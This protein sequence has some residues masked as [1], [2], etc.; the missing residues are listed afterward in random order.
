MADK[1]SKGLAD[2]VAASTALSDID[3]QRGPAVLPRVRHPPA[4]RI[5]RPSRKSPTCCSAAPPRAARELD[6][7]RAELAAGRPLGELVGSTTWPSVAG[8]QGPM[9]AMRTPG[10]AGQRRRSGQGLQR[11]RGQH[12]Q[13]GPAHRPAAGAGGRLPRRAAGPG[14]AARPIRASAWPRTSCCQLRG[15][16]R[17]PA[18]DA[19]IFDTCLVLHADHTMN[20]STFAARVCAATLSDMHSAVVAALGTLKGPL[21]GGANEQVMRGLEA[22]RARGRR[23]AGRGGQSQ[24]GERLS[25]GEKIMGFGHRVYK[26]EDPRAT[27]LRQMSAELAEAS[28]GRHLLP[29]VAPDGRGRAG[30]EGPVP[31]RRLLR[32]HRLPLPGHPDRPVHAGLLG[33]PDGRVDGARDRAARRQPADQAGQ[34]VHRRA[35]PHLGAARCRG[36]ALGGGAR[37]AQRQP[38]RHARAGSRAPAAPAAGPAG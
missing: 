32:R 6:E 5:A 29:D 4:R 16:R 31:E 13:G 20:A 25:Q 33:Q 38:G 37:P 36:E 11:A 17:R 35:R 19:E 15:Q 9:E 26:T 18:R 34:R 10:L 12:A 22:I 7:Y 2:V 30:G 23:S 8:R 28:R 1:P 24:A 3:G 21:H 27:H 14:P